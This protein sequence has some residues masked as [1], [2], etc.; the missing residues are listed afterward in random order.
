MSA[1]AKVKTAG[2]DAKGRFKAGIGKVT[3]SKRTQAHG[4]AGQAGAGVEKAPVK[5]EDGPKR[6]AAT[7]KKKTKAAAK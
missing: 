7:A 3:G 2:R 1:A 4:K 5:A 6:V